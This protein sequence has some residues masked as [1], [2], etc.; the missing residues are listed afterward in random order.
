MGLGGQVGLQG[1]EGDFLRSVDLGSFLF[2][3]VV[4]G[5]LGLLSSAVVLSFRP[6]APSKGERLPSGCLRF[7]RVKVKSG[8]QKGQLVRRCAKRG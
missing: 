8:F 6:E 5:V 1:R 7:R 2:G 3:G 4:G